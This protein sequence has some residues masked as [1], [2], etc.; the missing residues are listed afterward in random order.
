MNVPIRFSL[1][2][3]TALLLAGCYAV[4]VTGRHAINLVDDKDVTKM[5]IAMFDDMKRQYKLSRDRALNDQLRRVGE[6]IS[7]VVFWDMPDA[8]WEFVVFDVPQINA[9]AMAG[10]KVGVFT[11][12]FKIAKNDD[13]LASVIAH[14]I[15]HVTAK[16]V[17]EKLSQELAVGTIGTVGMIGGLAGGASGLTVNA[18]SQAYGITTTVGGLAFDRKKEKE[19]DY[20][21]LMYMARAGYDPEEAVKVLEALDAESASGPGPGA[22]LSTH[23]TNPERIIQ[24]MDAMPKAK[25]ERAQSGIRAAPVLVK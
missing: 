2:A 13:Q 20:I 10:G 21:G 9:F 14:E 5:S 19:A 3:C 12:L 7:K 24:L 6:R 8:E 15:A 16:H 11:G 23:P 1:A 18:L 17:H 4:P 22:F 25:A